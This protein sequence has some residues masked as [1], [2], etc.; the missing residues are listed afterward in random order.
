VSSKVGSVFVHRRTDPARSE[1]WLGITGLL[2]LDVVAPSLAT[3]LPRKRWRYDHVDLDSAVT[4][5]QQTARD[6]NDVKEWM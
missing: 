2:R 6:P 5:R 3:R 1:C 4:D